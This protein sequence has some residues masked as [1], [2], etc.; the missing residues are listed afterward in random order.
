MAIISKKTLLTFKYKIFIL[1]IVYTNK[2]KNSMAKKFKVK[3]GIMIPLTDLEGRNSIEDSI[4]IQKIVFA[5]GGKWRGGDKRTEI[6]THYSD[7]GLG[8]KKPYTA[9]FIDRE[10][11]DLLLSGCLNGERVAG[12]KEFSAKYF[13]DTD[14]TCPKKKK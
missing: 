10:G 12:Y 13:I 2:K 5:D 7:D 6:N 8:T 1:N 11:N 14:G 4:K 3:W 9:L